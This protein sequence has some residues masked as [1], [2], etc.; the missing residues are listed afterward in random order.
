MALNGTL[1]LSS[2]AVQPSGKAKKSSVNSGTSRSSSI[3]TVNVSRQSSC[4]TLGGYYSKPMTSPTSN[5]SGGSVI[6]QP[7]GGKIAQNISEN[8]QKKM[9][10]NLYG[11]SPSSSLSRHHTRRKSLDDLELM[12]KFHFHDDLSLAFKNFRRSNSCFS[13]SEDKVMQKMSSSSNEKSP[14][15]S[16]NH[17]E[18]IK[19]VVKSP[20]IASDAKVYNPFPVRRQT[21]LIERGKKMGLYAN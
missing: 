8:Y 18:P 17:H 19:I 14:K 7:I 12:K 21:H 13:F 11:D 5:M 1:P 2:K 4:D 20:N 10:K 6:K 9:P 3:T 15:T 16:V